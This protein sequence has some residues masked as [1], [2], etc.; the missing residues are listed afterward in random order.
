MF[1]SSCWDWE[2]TKNNTSLFFSWILNKLTN[3]IISDQNIS[4]MSVRL[5]KR[6]FPLLSEDFFLISVP[7]G[8][9][10][11]PVTG[12]AEPLQSLRRQ[13]PMTRFCGAQWPDLESLLSPKSCMIQMPSAPL[14]HPSEK[15]PS[16]LALT[17]VKRKR[18]LFFWA[19]LRM[20]WV[21]IGGKMI[22]LQLIPESQA[23]VHELRLPGL[24]RGVN[25]NLVFNGDKSFNFQGEEFCG[26]MVVTQPCE[27]T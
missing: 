18:S 24:G 25:A 13:G 9:Q 10:T 26:Q 21:S 22:S 23:H 1:S 12:R 17:E 2:G 20:L 19:K 5:K 8:P 15:P 11:H 7:T 14:K 3:K 27:G 6:V 4:F 16:S